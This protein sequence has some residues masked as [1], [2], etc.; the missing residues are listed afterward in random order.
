MR[1]PEDNPA[2]SHVLCNCKNHYYTLD[3]LISFRAKGERTR[4]SD[5][6]VVSVQEEGLRTSDAGVIAGQVGGSKLLDADVRILFDR[7][8][9]GDVIDALSHPARYGLSESQFMQFE[10]LVFEAI[11]KGR[12]I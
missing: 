5:A 6:G 4:M 3:S 8:A 11:Y 9:A 10:A 1:S 12:R 2:E 7:L